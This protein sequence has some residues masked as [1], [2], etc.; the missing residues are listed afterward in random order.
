MILLPGSQDHRVSFDCDYFHNIQN[1]N[2]FVCEME[3]S[4]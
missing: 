2:V 1:N 3:R 4:I